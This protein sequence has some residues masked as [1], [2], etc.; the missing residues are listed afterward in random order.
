MKNILK[1]GFLTMIYNSLKQ[2]QHWCP[3]N[4]IPKTGWEEKHQYK[5]QSEFIFKSGFEQS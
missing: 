5:T 3:N 1:A 2:Q 4:V